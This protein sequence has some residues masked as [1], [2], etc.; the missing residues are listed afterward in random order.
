VYLLS[1]IGHRGLS[2]S[3]SGM[4]DRSASPDNSRS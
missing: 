3:V 2:G 1:V 4:E